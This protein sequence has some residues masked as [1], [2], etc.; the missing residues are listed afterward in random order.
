MERHII[1]ADFG[2][3]VRS[4]VSAPDRLPRN[5]RPATM[6]GRKGKLDVYEIIAKKRFE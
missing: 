2:R 6:N 5:L 1:A 4:E 3:R